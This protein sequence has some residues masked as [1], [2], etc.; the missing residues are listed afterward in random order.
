V[1]GIVT[2]EAAARLIA[3]AADEEQRFARSLCDDERAS[4]GTPERWGAAATLAHLTDWKQVQVE[5]M[6]AHLERRQPPA[7]DGLPFPHREPAAYAP[8]AAIPW[9]GVPE[10]AARVSEALGRSAL[11]FR[12]ED[13]LESFPWT[14]GKPLAQQLLGR[15]VW[16]TLTHLSEYRRQRGR[17]EEARRFVAELGGLVA[18][19]E[20]WPVP[21]DP[22]GHYNIACACAAAGDPARARTLLRQAVEL[23]PALAAAARE[24]ADLV[25]VV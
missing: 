1:T 17:D 7:C 14:R 20:A 11:R 24:D 25:G 8:L 9:D 4:A 6:V 22:M 16:H 21:G 3:F 12:D 5:R 18:E 10:E 2:I 13:L 23:D 15:G 19:L